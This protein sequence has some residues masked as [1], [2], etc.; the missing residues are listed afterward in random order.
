MFY[1]DSNNRL[2]TQRIGRVLR[3]DKTNPNKIANVFDFELQRDADSEYNPDR[4]RKEWLS[5]ISFND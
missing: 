4:D 5:S 1:A 3:L 2:T